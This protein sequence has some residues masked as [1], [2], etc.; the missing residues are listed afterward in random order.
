M[1]QLCIINRELHQGIN[2][3]VRKVLL[4]SMSL[5]QG[6]KFTCLHGLGKKEKR[7]VCK[8]INNNHCKAF[9]SED[10]WEKMRSMSNQR[11]NAP[12]S[13]RAEATQLHVLIPK[14]EKMLSCQIFLFFKESQ[15]LGFYIKSP[16]FK[17][18]QLI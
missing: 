4:F 9:V 6:H 15:K 13:K 1:D 18:W 5:N 7:A 10:I 17:C 12:L 11:E 3:A 2:R 8:V 16:D 14:Q